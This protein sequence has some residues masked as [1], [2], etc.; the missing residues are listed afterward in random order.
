MTLYK[1]DYYFLYPRAQHKACGLKYCK[2]CCN[3][4]ISELAKVGKNETAFPL[5]RATESHWNRNIVSLGSSVT[6]LMHP[7][8]YQSLRPGQPPA[9]SFMPEVSMVI[10][11]KMY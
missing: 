10:G 2:Q 11:K 9:D 7:S 1:F 6:E 3:C 4:H 5:W 8:D